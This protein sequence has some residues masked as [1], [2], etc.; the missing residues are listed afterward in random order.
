MQI[1]SPDNLGFGRK[2]LSAK[3]SSNAHWI[4]QIEVSRMQIST[5]SKVFCVLCGELRAKRIENPRTRYAGARTS[6]PL[7]RPPS[8]AA[9][10]FRT[11]LTNNPV[12]LNIMLQL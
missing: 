4:G 8:T 2:I 7:P 6:C 12:K 10:P 3:F 9:A 5:K 1:L 11:D